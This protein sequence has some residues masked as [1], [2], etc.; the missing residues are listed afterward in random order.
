MTI[1]ITNETARRTGTRTEFVRSSYI[2]RSIGECRDGVDAMAFELA[3]E[4]GQ[5]IRLGQ[6]TAEPA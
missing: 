6:V 1:K 3:C 2:A 5:I 4:H